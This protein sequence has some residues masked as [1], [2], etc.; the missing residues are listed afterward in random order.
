MAQLLCLKRKKLKE[1]AL[2]RELQ[3]LHNNYSS[4]LA[5]R[6]LDQALNCN[7]EFEKAGSGCGNKEAFDHTSAN[8]C[9][10]NANLFVPTKCLAV[11]LKRQNTEARK[12][13]MEALAKTFN[14]NTEIGGGKS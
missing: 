11:M 5:S 8:F 2:L 7:G 10:S 12:A 4:Q 13:K 1:V 14:A 3:S 9:M 6:V